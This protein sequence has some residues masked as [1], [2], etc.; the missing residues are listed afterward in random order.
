MKI[1]IIVPIYGVEKYIKKHLKSLLNQ[2]AKDLELVFVNDCTKDR[3]IEILNEFISLF[4][5]ANYGVKVIN[6]SKNKG[7]AAARLTGLMH[8][9]GDYVWFIDSDDWIDSQSTIILSKIIEEYKPDIVQFSHIEET[10][11]KNIRRINDGVT[12]EK[13]LWLR[14]YPCIWRNIFKRQFLI[15]NDICPVADINYSEDFVMT[16]RAYALTKNII[17]LPNSYLYNYNNTNVDSYTHNISLKS[18]YNSIDGCN[19]LYVFYKSKGL[20]NAVKPFFIYV[21]LRRY[22]ELSNKDRS[23]LGGRIACDNIIKMYPK[24]L[25]SAIFLIKNKQT[26]LLYF[27]LRLY[28]IIRFN[29]LYNFFNHN[30]LRIISNITSVH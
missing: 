16:S 6:H 26:W 27:L 13:L 11:D 1:S 10:N 7:L 30:K 9:T 19:Y 20:L 8:S 17:L 18:L 15:E 28:R 21:Y 3:S 12:L 2:E 14:T 29:L 22:I 25:Q 23:Y 4:T 24:L 5:A